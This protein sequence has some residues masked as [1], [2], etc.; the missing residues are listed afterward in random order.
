M[1]LVP[2]LYQ[3]GGTLVEIVR[4]APLPDCLLR[5]ASGPQIVKLP[6]PRLR[7]LLTKV[8]DFAV[9]AGE[10]D[11]TKPCHPP[12]WLIKEIDARRNW[13]TVQHLEGIVQ[14]PVMLAG[15]SI[16]QQPGY[17]ARSGLF[18]APDGQFP[19]VPE[20]PT[21][22][23]AQIAC[24]EL[25]DIV[26]DF[27]FQKPAHR[28]AWLASLLTPLA[29]YAFEGPAPLFAIDAN[30]RGSGKSML[31]DCVGR[32]VCGRSLARTSAPNDDEEA[33]KKITSIALVGEPLVLIDNIA[34]TLGCASLD[35]ALTATT[36]TDRLLGKS[37]MTG[38]LPLSTVWFATGNNLVFAAD[39]ARRALHI[40]LESQLERPEDRGDFRHPDLLSWVTANRHRLAVAALT[41]L[42]AYHVA[43]RPAM[44]IKP[45]GS[46]EEWSRLVRHAV[47]WCGLSDPGETRQEVA[48]QSDREA[49]L[50]RLLIDAWKEVDPESKGISVATAIDASTEERFPRMRAAIGELTTSGKDPNSRSIGMK[51]SHLRGRICGG[52]TFVSEY[53]KSG[54]V[55]RIAEVQ[56]NSKSDSDGGTSG[57]SGTNSDP[58]ARDQE[59]Q[60]VEKGAHTVTGRVSSASPASPATSNSVARAQKC[61]HVDPA[62]WIHR[63]GKAHC[64]GCDKILGNVREPAKLPGA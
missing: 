10:D 22:Q 39:T 19:A 30:V 33:R 42:R 58:H 64:P 48:M 5:A 25:L 63:L 27:P 51:L 50:L 61:D 17:D 12:E 41:L 62:K 44:D 18:L 36:W 49:Q 56:A 11:E 24:D 46:F 45:W 23:D 4:D 47:V 59:N 54:S 37:Q 38:E 1:P 28:A 60:H 6:Q 2:N 32:I 14:T 3:R 35:A 7:E 26:A 16:L 55:W 53:G 31:A 29:R 21:V 34:G 20:S 13:P 15:G 52:R 8:A 57:T 40:R 9:I 43:G